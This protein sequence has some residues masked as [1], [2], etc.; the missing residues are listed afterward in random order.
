MPKPSSIVARIPDSG[1]RQIFE[2]SLTLD[3][4][5]PL[6]VG[7]PDLPVDQH[8]LEAG[9]Q[10]WLRDDTDY[11]PNSGIE[12]L[13]AALA[14]KIKSYNRYTTFPEHVHV[15]AGGSNSLHMAMSLTLGPGDEILVPDP[16]YATFFMTPVLVGASAAG[17]P[18]RP[19]NG[20]IPDIA[21]LEALVTDKT[22]AVLINS[23]SNP[24]GV[25]FDAEVLG[26]LLEF[27][28]KHDLWVISDEVY[29]YLTYDSEFV[30]IASLDT[31]DRVLSVYSLS[32]TYGLTGGRVGYLVTPPQLSDKVGALQEA[33]VSCVNTPAQYAALAAVEG[34][35]DSV[36]LAA[37]HYRSNLEKATALLDER[38]FTYLQPRGA[39]YLFINVEHASGGDVAEWAKQFLLDHHVAVA[40]GTAFGDRGEGWIR[41]CYAGDEQQLLEGL[42]RL[43]VKED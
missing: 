26:R 38:G 15:G 33:N 19:E 25:V 8:V 6:S 30:S 20:F 5:I 11:A 14:K 22:R 13:R 27:A 41:I 18:L 28:R 34:P 3:D 37:E 12:P 36:K 7:E 4:V 2:L 17:Y 32:K 24:L 23:P 1:I 40:P 10:A 16:G 35:Q 31:D 9:A 43:P 29:E 39:F 21:D 42:S